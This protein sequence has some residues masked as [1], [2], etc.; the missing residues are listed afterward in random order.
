MGTLC[1]NF[2]CGINGGA[3]GY[4]WE[5]CVLTFTVVLMEE[6]MATYRNIVF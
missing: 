6:L 4:I 1:S 2:Y 5:H 3:D